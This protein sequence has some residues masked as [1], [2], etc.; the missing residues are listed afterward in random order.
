MSM[1]FWFFQ[2]VVYDEFILLSHMCSSRSVKYHKDSRGEF[3]NDSMLILSTVY[4][5]QWIIVL[6]AQAHQGNVN[7]VLKLHKLYKL[8]A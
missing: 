5:D 2:F 3:S 1:V 6:L 8:Q 4:I 7:I